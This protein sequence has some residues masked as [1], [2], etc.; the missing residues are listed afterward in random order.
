MRSLRDDLRL[1]FRAVARRRGM[2]ALVVLSVAV[3][4]GVNTTFFGVLRGF[5][6]QPL[7]Y[8]NADRLVILWLLQRG[9]AE[10]ETPASPADF[11]A[12]QRESKSFESLA[13]LVVGQHA[14]TSTEPREEVVGERVTAEALALFDGEALHGRLLQP[15]DMVPGAEPVVVLGHEYW[16]RRFAGDPGAVGRSLAVDERDHTIVGVL[17]PG[18]SYF[19]SNRALWLPLPID[20][21]RASADGRELIV[22]GRL[23][24]GTSVEAATA[25]LTAIAERRAA[26]HPESNAGYGAMARLLRDQVP[27]P[28]DRQLFSLV[29][30]A[31]SLL[32]LLACANVASV[33]IASGQDRHREIAVRSALGSAPGRVLRQLLLESML[34]AGGAA[35]GGIALAAVLI[36]VL[37]QALAGEL[38]P[39]LLPTVDGTVVLFN[40]GLAAVAAL[41]FGLGPAL[42]AAR[43]PLASALRQRGGAAPHRRLHKV[44]VV[45][46]VTLALVM[47]SATGLLISSL[48]AAYTL[49]GGYAAAELLTLRVALPERYAEGD[50]AAAHERLRT[51]LA[52]VPGVRSASAV[53]A[54]PR[55]RSL[56]S[57]PFRVE[58]Q[59]PPADGQA[60]SSAITLAVA[61]DYFSTM[62]IGLRGG[63]SFDGRD[64]GSGAPVALVSAELA[65]RHLRGDPLGQR[66]VIDGRPRQVV[67]IVADVV[68]TRT[69]EPGGLRNPVVYL[70]LE[71]EPS[72]QLS[73][74]LRCT[75]PPASLVD[76]ARQAVGR[77][78]PL[79]VAGEM[80]TM[81]DHVA[82]QFSGARVFATMLAGF[83]AVALALAVLGVYGV[84]AYTVARRRREL[85]VRM[86]VGA[87]PRDVVRELTLQGGAMA[88]LGLLIALPAVFLVGRAIAG[89][90]GGSFPMVW[91]TLPA[92]AA[93]LGAAALLASWVPARRAARLDPVDVLAGE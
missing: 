35:L 46:E 15:A 22:F 66:L 91:G 42:A 21:E 86:A 80:R 64:T 2:A 30:G 10:P 70:P 83:G 8:A 31:I 53:T 27:G 24:E 84:I 44:L 43:V 58:G 88:G 57:R 16:Q 14:V 40:V 19:Q 68:E 20:P 63:R 65:R 90:F 93:I 1:A 59:A 29:Q 81:D 77:F 61:G 32:L 71:Q 33:L 55:S 47:L 13:A 23:R 6:W 9:A 52:A 69:L 48:R 50:V 75:V 28:S 34:L 76:V 39:A 17:T 85:S 87:R 92:L 7:P 56:P 51:E 36:Y 78:D 11:V 3:A 82:A 60:D 25:E 12:W 45:L 73:Y 79:L 62:G 38:G 26:A 49:D 54:L 67:G 41:L 37:R 74:V 89:I 72:R 18:F 4:I 5:M